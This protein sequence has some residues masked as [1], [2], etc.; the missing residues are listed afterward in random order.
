MFPIISPPPPAIV[1]YHKQNV[2]NVSFKGDLALL[3]A[4]SVLSNFE[5]ISKIYRESG[6]CKEISNYIKKRLESAGF[7]LDRKKDGTICAT[8]GLNANRDNAIILQAHM[9][10]VAESKDGNPRKP[11]KL[12][13]KDGW[14]Y[15][16]GRTLGADN[17]IGVATILSIAD[18]AKFKKYPLELII[19]TDEETTM[20]GAS[21]LLPQDFYGKFLINLDSEEIGKITKG[22]AGITQ[23]EVAKKIKTATLNNNQYSKIRIKI[24]GGSGGHSCLIKNDTFN[25]LQ[26]VLQTLKNSDCKLVALN[27]GNKLNTIPTEASVEILVPKSQTQEIK[28]KLYKHLSEVEKRNKQKNPDLSFS[29]A[30]GRA[31]IGLKYVD[32]QTQKRLLD[33][34]AKV[35]TGLLSTFD[36]GFNKT[37]QNLGALKISD[38]ICSIKV[39]GRSADPTDKEGEE[40]K[41]RTIEYLSAA[42]NQKVSTTCEI[43]TWRAKSNSLLENKAI[44][45]YS[46]TQNDKTPKIMIEHGGLEPAVFTSKRPDL[47][48]ISIGPTIEDPHSTKERL[49]IDTVPVFYNWL[50]KILETFSQK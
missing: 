18:D 33:K 23:Y 12:N 26:T 47:D 16:N 6:H 1:S 30:S 49:K 7:A 28:I 24:K 14:L 46:K 42:F 25:P 10:M 13:M 11:I 17:G 21:A 45:A 9:D 39:M 8:R 31:E 35:P 15:A 43:P 40:L 20:G 34:L 44:E 38:G 32:E 22:C 37:S 36:D 4:S 41:R 27:G 29:I 3:R 5:E 19:T 50:V 48:Q 2:H